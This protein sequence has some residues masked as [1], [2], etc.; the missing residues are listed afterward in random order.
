M[1]ADFAFVLG[2]AVFVGIVILAI[3]TSDVDPWD[4]L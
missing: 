3:Q 1:T 2:L 4:D